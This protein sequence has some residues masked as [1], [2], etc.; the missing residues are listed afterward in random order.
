[1]L[2]DVKVPGEGRAGTYCIVHTRGTCTERRE[3]EREGGL[4]C[5]LDATVCDAG[6]TSRQSGD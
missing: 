2:F 6:L 4:M 5:C 1:M 3:R